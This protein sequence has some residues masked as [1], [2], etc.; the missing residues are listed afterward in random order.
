MEKGKVK[1]PTVTTGLKANRPSR[2]PTSKH[3]GALADQWA[4]YTQAQVSKGDNSVCLHTS[5][6]SPLTT[7]RYHSLFAVLPAASLATYSRDF[8]LLCSALGEFF[9]RLC[10]WPPP[11]QVAPQ[12]AFGGPHSTL[13]SHPKNSSDF[14]MEV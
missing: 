6:P 7:A 4:T 2:Q 12:T 13:C 9:H 5:S 10:C 8:F 14:K 11:Y 3:P 1:G